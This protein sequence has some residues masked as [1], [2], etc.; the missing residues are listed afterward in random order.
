VFPGRTPG[1]PD[2]LIVFGEELT[3]SEVVVGKH[4]TTFAMLAENRWGGKRR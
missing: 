4:P 1:Q 3:S 2:R